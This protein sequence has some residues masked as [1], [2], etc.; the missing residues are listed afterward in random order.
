MIFFNAIL[1]IAIEFLIKI[2]K[3]MNEIFPELPTNFSSS[4]KVIYLKALSRIRRRKE[5]LYVS[6]LQ[7][8]IKWVEIGILSII[9]NII[10]KR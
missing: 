8:K 10:K 5:I 4:V 3:Y 2:Y 1:W 7:N 9:K 6:V